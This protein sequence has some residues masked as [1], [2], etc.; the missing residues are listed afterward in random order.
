MAA[1]GIDDAAER[2]RFLEKECAGDAPLRARVEALLKMNEEA[3]EFLEPEIHIGD[4]IGYFGDFV[5]LDEI[6]RGSS[7]VVFRARQTSLNRVVAL[8][9]LRDPLLTN[10]EDMKRFR[11]EAQAAAALDH[12]GIVP[13]YEVGELSGQGYFS[14]KFIEGGT[15][16]LRAGEF[17]EPR[18]A[19]ALM[20]QVARAVHHAHE[21]GILHR[22]LKPGNIL[23]DRT[24][25]PLVT[26]FGIARRIGLDST[27]TQTGQIVGTPHYMSP[28]QAQGENSALSAASDIYSMGAVLYE[29]LSGNKPFDGKIMLTLLRQVTEQSPPPLRIGDRD[30]ESIVMRSLE[31]HPAARQASAAVFADELERWLRGEVLDRRVAENRRPIFAGLALLMVSI[32][33]YFAFPREEPGT[34][35]AP[36]L[37]NPATATVHMPLPSARSAE[38]TPT[39]PGDWSVRSQIRNWSGAASSADGR[40]L[41]ALDA[42]GSIYTS[43]DAGFSWTERARGKH[44]WRSVASSADGNRLVAVVSNGRIYTSGDSG[45]NWVAREQVRDWTSVAA[46]ADGTRIVATAF[47]NHIYTSADS[48]ATWIARENSR[49]WQCVASSSDG[50]KLVAAVHGGQIHTSADYGETWIAR[51][52]HRNWQSLAS[53]AD[54]GKLVAVVDGGRIYTSTDSGVSW[55]ESENVRSWQSVASSADG[56]TLIAVAPDHPVFVSMDSGVTWTARDHARDWRAATCSA[57]GRLLISAVMGGHIYCVDSSTFR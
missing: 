55:T 45:I 15:L 53:S 49:P 27:L 34:A 9:L 35:P 1:I 26:D 12:P 10:G 13:V 33:A 43:T 39:L 25:A 32:A 5:M 16:H 48:G 8:K 18:K 11:A 44:A 4:S 29:L 3:G 31:K 21:R 38:P 22:D 40:K 50:S 57:D 24:G 41:V 6:A 52:N 19:A 7:G 42:P 47:L 54:G 2:A 30:L 51:E 56:E 17:R 46:S 23:I 20:A 37:S 36:A 14:M 28:E